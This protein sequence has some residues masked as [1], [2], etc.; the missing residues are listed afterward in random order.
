MMYLEIITSSKLLDV[1]R[2]TLII[3]NEI[4]NLDAGDND[5]K[6]FNEYSYFQTKHVRLNVPQH[7]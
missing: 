6:I 5:A 1:L 7:A 4:P 3:E 2:W